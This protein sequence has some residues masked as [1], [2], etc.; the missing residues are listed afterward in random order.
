VR[1]GHGLPAGVPS[2]GRYSFLIRLKTAS[3]GTA[4]DRARSNGKSVKAAK[5]SA[6]DQLTTVHT[7]QNSLVR[8]LPAKTPVLYRLHAVT[9]AVAVT[10]DVKNYDALT[11]M[12]NVAAVYPIAPKKPTNSYAVPLQGAPAVWGGDSHD[13]GTGTVVA[14]IDT[15]FDYTHADFGGPGTKAAY[16]QAFADDTKAPAAGS[17]DPNKFDAADSYDLVGDTYNAD[18]SGATG[19]YQPVPQPD[20]NPLDCD[21]AHGGDGH[22]SHTAG[23]IAGFGVNSDGTT[24]GVDAGGAVDPS[25][26]SEDTPFDSLKIGPG[27]APG[28]RII[29]YRVFG[30][31]GSSNVIS[32]AI[33]MAMDPNGDGDTSDHVDVINM[34]LGS[35]FGSPEDGDS[36]IAGDAEKL[37]ITVAVASG[38]NDDVPDIGGSPGS[39]PQVLT[40]AASQDAQSVADGTSVRIDGVAQDPYAAERATKYPWGDAAATGGGDLSGTV[41]I[42]TDDKDGCQPFDAT[43]KAAIAGKVVFL[44]WTDDNL[45]CGSAVRGENVREA[46][47]IGFILGSNLEEFSAGITGDQGPQNSDGTYDAEKAIPGVLVNK[48]AADAIRTAVGAG[49]DVVVTGTSA[50]S[51]KQN[52]PGDDDKVARFSSRGVHAAG[53][54]KPDVSAVGTTV[55]S[56]L[57][58]SGSDGQSMSGT[59]MAT[60]MVAGLA[61]LVTAAH[62]SWT[63]EQVKADIMNTADKNLYTG[64]DPGH[65]NT[66]SGDRYAPNRVGAGRIDA[67]SALANDVLAYDEDDAGAVSVSFGPVE[68][69][70]SGSD[71]AMTKT[72]KVQNFGDTPATYTADYDAID[73]MP[74]VQYE[75]STD[76]ASGPGRV[77]VPAAANGVPGVARVVVTLEIPDPSALRKTVDPTYWTTA[78]DGAHVDGSGNPLD[79]LADASGNLEMVPDDSAAPSLR[80]PVYSAPRPTAQLSVPGKV[81]LTGSGS[82]VVTP[83]GYGVDAEDANPTS[84][85]GDVYSIGAGFELQA[86]S[87]SDPD[88]AT[89]VTG[90]CISIPSERGADL[91]YVGTTSD[92]PVYG[93]AANSMAYFALTS[94]GVNTTPAGRTEDDVFLDVDR[95]G[96]PDLVVDNTVLGESAQAAEPLYLAEVVDLRTGEVVDDEA[97]DGRLGDLDLAV[98]DSDTVVLPVWLKLLQQYGV[99]ASSPR[100][101]YGVVTYSDE[102][103][104][105][106]D[107]V[108]IDPDTLDMRSP[109]STDVYKPAVSVTEPDVQGNPT[110]PLV[111]DQNNLTLN[112]RRNASTYSADQGKGL[113]YVHFHNAAGKKAQVASFATES[114]TLG[115]SALAVGKKGTVTASVAGGGVPARG[116]VTFTAAGKTIGTATLSGGKATLAYT[117]KSGG[118]VKLAATYTPAA[119]DTVYSPTSAS[120]T[121]SI[122]KLRSVP[123][124]RLSPNPVRKGK[125]VTATVV[126]PKVSGFTPTGR[127]TLKVAGHSVGTKSLVSG[128]VTVGFTRTT[129]GKASVVASYAGSAVYQAA[130]SKAVTLT[131][132]R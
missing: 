59:S 39:S 10:T 25:D 112:V 19:R 77:T 32:Q 132:K 110:G 126:V 67:A 57:P 35:D 42:P 96:T 73:T 31:Y 2:S 29:A 53:D 92:Y 85:A 48:D 41:V 27:M 55:F 103:G 130:N 1:S 49:Q 68:V 81:A 80:V 120:K 109:L 26:Y 101:D 7:A 22:G 111:D 69:P 9:S 40:V 82:G 30:C 124:V 52:Y 119:S 118:S 70:M 62:P 50:N 56:T 28:A 97:L 38:N 94:Q 108:G 36:V 17:Y 37:G 13:L 113:L 75:L 4:F 33:D 34:S 64:G 104:S 123:T 116:T 20:P 51:V 21:A 115:A 24:Y 16:D 125:K 6:R 100:I 23:S 46:G 63:S 54:V 71:L 93:D 74:G 91:K 114:M 99:N 11:T 87:G 78:A 102:T 117:P 128:R 95:D 66:G 43:D 47:G 106:I 105:V 14:D 60:P 72:V 65:D 45:E 18:D 58:G 89:G 131:V 90:P 88:C 44:T 107:S 8:S 129:L 127:V 98:Y 121:V 3:T 86:T 5:E 76:T 12:A 122:T 15:G 84:T 61:A 83:S 79:T